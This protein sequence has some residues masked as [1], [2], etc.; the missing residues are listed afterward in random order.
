MENMGI[1]VTQKEQFW[2]GKQVFITGHT[3][4]KGSWL[5]LVLQHFGASITGYAL[6][7]PTKPSLYELAGLQSLLQSN[8]RDIRDFESLQAALKAAEPEI[9]FHLA[10]Q[11]IV[12]ESYKDPLGTYSTNI[13][14]TANLLQAARFV[15]SVRAIVVITTDKCY[16]NREWIWPY[17]ESDRLGGYD[18]YSSSKAC[19]ELV[20]SSMRNS[21][22]HPDRYDQHGVAI[23][24]VRAGNVLGGGDWARD[25]LV[26][27]VIR[28]FLK[29]EK[30]ILRNPSAVRP[31]QHVLEPLSG[32]MLV[33]ENLYR[34]GVEF[35]ETWNFGPEHSD[36]KPVEWIV[37]T[38]CTLWGSEAAYEIEQN[39]GLHE[40]HYLKLD[41]S[42]ARACLDWNPKWNLLTALERTIE[43]ARVYQ[44]AGDI[45]AI[46][47]RQIEEYFNLT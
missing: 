24:S 35:G 5:A 37:R 19:A 14:G 34:E 42:K 31:W 29:N 39:P 28:A 25:R 4:F 17:R 47:H 3:G 8:I 16:E 38:L 27:D 41:W 18:P 13:L 45:R 40:A 30:V 46:C 23:A 10:A 1:E 44:K 22:F 6:D 15:P 36:A 21:F 11:P 9:I 26:P 32:Y 20:T 12:L 7:P 2:K 33:A 43:W